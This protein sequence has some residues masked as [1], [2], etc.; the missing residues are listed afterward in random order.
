MYNSQKLNLSIEGGP[1]TLPSGCETPPL[2]GAP[3]H[4]SGAIPSR[5]GVGFPLPTLL[6]G[7]EV[8]ERREE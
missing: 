6:E 1:P 4:F 8:G 2:T 5:I 7:G 3:H